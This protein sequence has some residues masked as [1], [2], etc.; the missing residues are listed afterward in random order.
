MTERCGWKASTAIY[1]AVGGFRLRGERVKSD[2]RTRPSSEGGRGMIPMAKR[3]WLMEARVIA[4]AY[5]H[6]FGALTVAL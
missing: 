3:N 1:S 4:R 5:A 2:F 6:Y